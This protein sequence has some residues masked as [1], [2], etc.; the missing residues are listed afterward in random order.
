MLRPHLSVGCSG[1]LRLK[2]SEAMRL[3]SYY[4]GTMA[5]FNYRQP[6]EAICAVPWLSDP[7][8]FGSRRM[9]PKKGLTTSFPGHPRSW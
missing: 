8:R 7:V 6:S 4:T 2:T 9:W 1:L 3:V 5:C